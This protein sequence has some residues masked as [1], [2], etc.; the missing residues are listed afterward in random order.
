LRV[1]VDDPHPQ[2][3]GGQQYGGGDD[4]VVLPTLPD[5]LATV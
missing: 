3:G 4:E 2:A 1:E 5:M